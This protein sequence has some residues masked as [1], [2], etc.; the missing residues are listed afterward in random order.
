L[1]DKLVGMNCYDNKVIRLAK[2]NNYHF[3]TKVVLLLIRLKI[4]FYQTL[5][6]PYSFNK[7]TLVADRYVPTTATLL[8]H[9]LITLLTYNPQ[10]HYIHKIISYGKNSM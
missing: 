6:I 8:P 4:R 10:F 9:Y 1:I 5:F 2:N 3:A 7:T